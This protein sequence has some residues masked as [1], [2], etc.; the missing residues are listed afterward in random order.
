MTGKQ[1]EK[2]EQEN[3]WDVAKRATDEYYRL[4]HSVQQILGKALGYPWCKDDPEN[5]PGTNEASGV[6]VGEHTAE[7]LAE[8]AA[9]KL[10]EQGEALRIVRKALE[11]DDIDLQ[12]AALA[13]KAARAHIEKL[14]KIIQEHEH[15]K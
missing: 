3:I 2:R 9:R 11:E 12:A 7:N 4:K 10:N 14:E 1:D 8:E 6:C 13:L 15:A 5:F